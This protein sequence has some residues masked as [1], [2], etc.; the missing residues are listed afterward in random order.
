MTLFLLLIMISILLII[1]NP[2][3]SRIF[4]QYLGVVLGISFAYSRS[5]RN[6]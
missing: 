1:G 3:G 5:N 6:K 2:M 4:A